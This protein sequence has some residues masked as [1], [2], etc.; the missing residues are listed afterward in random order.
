MLLKDVLLQKTVLNEEGGGGSY[1]DRSAGSK[2][3]GSGDSVVSEL[4]LRGNNQKKS[5]CRARQ[6]RLFKWAIHSQSIL[7]S[8]FLQNYCSK[9]IV[10]RIQLYD[11]W[12]SSAGS[13]CY[14]Q[15]RTWLKLFLIHF[16]P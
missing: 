7:L 2:G 8:V 15:H 10:W 12:D 13:D 16:V 3:G 14:L 9:I 4:K 5:K 6:Y 1:V 11:M